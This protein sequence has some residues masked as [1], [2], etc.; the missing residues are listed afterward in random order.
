MKTA[1]IPK[2]ECPPAVDAKRNGFYNAR[3]ITSTVCAAVR[4]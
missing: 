3:L 2:R 1:G 4:P